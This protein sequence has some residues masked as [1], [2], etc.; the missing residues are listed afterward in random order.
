MM[1]QSKAIAIL[2]SGKNVFL[3]GS[4]GAGKTYVL[5][6]YIGYLKDN[7]IPVAITAS[8]GIAATHMNGMT[9]HSWAGIGVKDTL[10]PADLIDIKN[11]KY[12]TDK[13]DTV[14][15][16][17]IDEISML[18]KQQLEMVNMVLKYVKNTA[19]PFGGIQVV[20]CGDFFQLPPVGRQTE[21][22]KDKFAFMSMAWL[23][24]APIV[25][26]IDEQHR[27]SDNSLNKILNDIRSGQ[28]SQSTLDT[29]TFA[30]KNN[31]P[32]TD[33]IT[34]LYTHNIDV[35]R[36]NTERLTQLFTKSKVFQAELKG[37]EKLRDMLAKSVLTDVLLELKI[38]TKVMFIKNNYEKGYMNGTLGEVVDFTEDDGYP[39]VKILNGNTITAEPE[40]WSII[41]EAGVTL[42]SY[43]QVPLRLAWAITVHKSQGMTLDA[44]E[45]DLS[46]T[47]ERGQGYVALS[48]LK[49]IES[50]F[51]TGFNQMALQIDPLV[52]KADRRFKELST[53]ADA[54]WYDE[55]LE[56]FAELFKQVCQASVSKIEAKRSAKKRAIMARMAEN[57]DLAFEKKSK[58]KKTKKSD[59]ESTVSAKVKKPSTY[60]LTAELVN[61][62][63]SLTSI[64]NQRNIS[65]GT[66]M[67]H[68]QKL[69]NQ[70]VELDLTSIK[71]PD[72][73]LKSVEV[74]IENLGEKAR[75]EQGRLLLTP[76]HEIL[77]A[78]YDYDELRCAVL[79]LE[80]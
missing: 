22:N 58:P 16:L 21:E 28:T 41:D 53:E 32:K 54:K 23:E 60:E 64:A 55:E 73:T 14:Q 66:V 11:K 63:L 71:P 46:K 12:I 34:R 69:V 40:V 72:E 45:V 30:L 1:K 33:F 3:T 77:E 44:A 42:A 52:L 47:F 17:I 48:R 31:A 67:S 39:M 56:K 13:I 68:I 6:Q 15:V 7:K 49:D 65:V 10:S 37:N 20:F 2:K 59:K 8:T 19:L 79:F 78:K 36:I 61:Q 9:I 29:L 80:K 26:Y 35:D 27:Q 62:G 76:I 24:A 51:L 70:G 5:N 57:E 18:H 38:G 4:A 74:A 25:C 50:L 75:N 43:T